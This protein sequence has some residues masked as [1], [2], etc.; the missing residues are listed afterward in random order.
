ALAAQLDLVRLWPLHQSGDL[1]L[2]ERRVAVRTT[3]EECIVRAVDVEH[4]HGPPAYLD[5]LA[6]ARRE[7]FDAA[8][9]VSRHRIRRAA[10]GTCRARCRRRSVA[11]SLA[12]TG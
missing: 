1:A 6:A 10:S 12:S 3:I 2:T 7:L 11:E 9:D 4:A 8:N 5:D